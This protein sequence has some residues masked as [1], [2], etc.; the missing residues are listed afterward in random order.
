MDLGNYQQPL[1]KESK[2][3]S[4]RDE[5]IV[6]FLEKINP[7]RE[8]NGYHPLTAKEFIGKVNKKFG[9]TDAGWLYL[10]YKKC[11]KFDEFSAGFNYLTRIR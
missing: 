5:Y 3:R 8:R 7:V 6:K 11:E 4:Q 10:L 1:F 2:L 9:K